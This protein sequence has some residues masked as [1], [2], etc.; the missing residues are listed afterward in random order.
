MNC[1]GIN[2]AA[3]KENNLS[4]V[5]RLIRKNKGCSR[6]WLSQETGLTSASIGKLVGQL[7][8]WGVVSEKEGY[9]SEVGR[10]PIRLEVNCGQ[11]RSAA[12]RINRDVAKLAVYD[13]GGRIICAD[14][15]NLAECTSPKESLRLISNRLNE[16][17]AGLDIQPMCI[18]V[19]IPGPFNYITGQVSA[20]SE[21]PEWTSVDIKSEIEA[22]CPLPVFVEHDG[23]C[24]ALAEI[25]YGNYPEDS[26][27][28][29]ITA[30]KGVGGGLIINGNIYH[31]KLGYSG[32]IGHTSIN[33]FG[34]KCSCGNRGCLELYGSTSAMRKM[35]I[36]QKYDVLNVP[37]HEE[38][39][40]EIL[41]FV[42]SGD[43]LACGVYKKTVS[44][45][46]FGAVGIINSFN[47][48]Y[49]V[50]ADRLTY[51]GEL[52][53]ETVMDT[54]RQY[55]M[56]EQ[57]ESMEVRTSSFPAEDPTLLGASV[58]AFDNMLNTPSLYFKS[59]RQST[60]G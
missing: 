60:G 7:I 38:T 46:A 27:L 19:A 20:S 43:P 4:L 17:S 41:A 53:I 39:V 33:M 12:V 5:L 6:I 49:V 58:M 3:Q 26:N 24:G 37:E 55:L 35:Y 56:P 23:K 18:G 51:G 48:G 31:G 11:F 2:Q 14:S 45:L 44:Y 29:F 54:L 21:F 36:A 9:G 30:D 13:F 32:E 52:F 10:K 25:R 16:L 50:F 22:I 8:D 1:I 15:C 28:L 42:R 57:M 47:P 34:P 40:E 59:S